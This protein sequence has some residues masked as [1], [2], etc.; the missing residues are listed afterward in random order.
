MLLNCSREMKNKDGFR[1]DYDPFQAMNNCS[2]LL[3]VELVQHG[4]QLEGG[5]YLNGEPH[6]YRKDKLKVYCQNGTVWV[7][8]EGG[9]CVSL[10]QWLMEFGGA[11]DYREAVKMIKGESQAPPSIAF[12]NPILTS[13]EIVFISMSI[14]FV[15]DSFII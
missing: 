13:R 9:R 10:T 11:A 14:L 12:S 2:K 6:P 15:S 3:G 5:C 4:R 7:S 1:F 8:E